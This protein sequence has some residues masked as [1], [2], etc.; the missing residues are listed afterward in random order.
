MIGV[1]V[2]RLRMIIVLLEVLDINHESK[3]VA[4]LYLQ[5]TLLINALA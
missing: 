3:D 5:E 1:Y 4:S 2:S